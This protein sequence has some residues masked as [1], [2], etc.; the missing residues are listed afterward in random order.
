[1]AGG[2]AYRVESWKPGVETI[3]TRFDDWKNGP[4][5]KLRRIIARDIPSPSTRRVLIERGD[6]DMS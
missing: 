1:M 4:L 5:P 2:G 3:Y 6:A